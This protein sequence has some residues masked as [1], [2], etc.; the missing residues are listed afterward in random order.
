M[1]EPIEW[2]TTSYRGCEIHRMADNEFL[3]YEVGEGPATAIP[4]ANVTTY[5]EARLVVDSLF[6]L[7]Q[8]TQFASFL[9]A[10]EGGK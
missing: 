4:Y 9:D 1:P 3:V 2:T 7:Y 8:A 5:T 6:S 10:L